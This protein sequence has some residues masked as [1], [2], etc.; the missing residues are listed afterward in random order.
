M[1]I[2]S[3][4]LN[5]KNSITVSK[6]ADSCHSKEYTKISL[7]RGFRPGNLKVNWKKKALRHY[8]GGMRKLACNGK[9]ALCGDMSEKYVSLDPTARFRYLANLQVLGLTEVDDLWLRGTIVS[10]SV[11]AQR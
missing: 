1:S 11:F 3:M 6:G 7:I 5:G 2:V 10:S 8:V 9:C 4:Q